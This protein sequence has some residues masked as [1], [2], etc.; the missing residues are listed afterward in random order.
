MVATLK[1]NL[2]EENNEFL[3]AT[4]GAKY[5]NVLHS[6]SEWF[7]LYRKHEQGPLSVETIWNAFNEHLE[8]VNL[9]EID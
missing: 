7:R 6:F 8:E 3:L 2:P 5:F 1:F 9:D 4:N